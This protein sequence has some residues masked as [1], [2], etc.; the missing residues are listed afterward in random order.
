MHVLKNGYDSKADYVSRFKKTQ[1]FHGLLAE[2][3]SEIVKLR[4]KIKYKD[5]TY[6]FK[7][8][9]YLA[10]LKIL[11]FLIVHLLF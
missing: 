2:K 9:V 5:L 4:E 3:K 11:V 10:Y 1:I 8:I 7:N 6:H